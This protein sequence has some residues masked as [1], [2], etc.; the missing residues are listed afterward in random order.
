MKEIERDE[1]L[2]RLDERMKNHLHWH[3]L[4]EAKLT[5]WLIALTVLIISLI[6]KGFLEWLFF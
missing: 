5:K 1:L 6:G 3:E 2:I 4:Y